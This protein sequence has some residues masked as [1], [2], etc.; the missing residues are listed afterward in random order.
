MWSRVVMSILEFTLKTLID[1]LYG[2]KMTARPS[3]TGS[4]KYSVRP[5]KNLNKFRKYF[6]MI[7]INYS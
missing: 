7:F 4:L 2:L 3:R 5:V 1:F 6:A